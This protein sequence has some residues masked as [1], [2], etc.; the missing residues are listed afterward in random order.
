MGKIECIYV[1][2]L[3]HAMSIGMTELKKES[4]PNEPSPDAL[5]PHSTS[6]IHDIEDVK[7]QDNPTKYAL[8]TIRVWPPIHAQY[9]RIRPWKWK[10]HIALRME[11]FG[12]DENSE[13]SNEWGYLNAKLVTAKTVCPQFKP[14]LLEKMKNRGTECKAIQ[15]DCRHIIRTALSRCGVTTYSMVDVDANNT[16]LLCTMLMRFQWNLTICVLIINIIGGQMAM[17]KHWC[18]S[19]L[20]TTLIPT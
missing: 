12:R 2:S 14:Q 18:I 15:F 1:G 17:W 11:L 19:T 4:D 16:L 10:L 3:H 8:A 9:V 6:T 7:L 5:G 20:K 13:S